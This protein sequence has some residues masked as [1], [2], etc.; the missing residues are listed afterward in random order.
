MIF[1][2]QQP[3]QNESDIKCISVKK[4][5]KQL[6]I[7]KNLGSNQKYLVCQ[8]NQQRTEHFTLSYLCKYIFWKLNSCAACSTHNTANF[9]TLML[10]G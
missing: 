10:I 1:K 7:L 3:L 6:S 5:V 4:K 9:I 2:V 8:I